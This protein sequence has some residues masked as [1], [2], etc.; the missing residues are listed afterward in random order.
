AHNLA[1]F[2][3]VILVC[4]LVIATSFWLVY[5]RIRLN[6]NA[7]MIAL[8]VAFLAMTSS[9]LHWLS[10]PHIFTFLFL[11][12][13]IAVLDRM[14][15]GEV[16]RWWLL[17]LLM[18]LW[19]NFH[20]A[21]IAG[22]MTWFLFGFGILMDQVW[23]KK[24]LGEGLPPKF[25][26]FY[27]LGGGASLL[28]SFINPAGIGIWGTSV[29]YLGESFLVDMTQEYQSPDFHLYRMWPFL[30]FI[31]LLIILFAINKR[32]RK[33]RDLVPA[34]AWM[35][36]GLYS[37]RNIPLF[38]IISAPLLATELDSLFIT[39]A[40]KFKWVDKLKKVD[41][42]YV[43][44]DGQL[45]GVVWPGLVVLLAVVGLSL[46]FT[47]DFQQSG[48]AY[49]PEVF[50]VDAVAWLDENPQEGNMFN[51]FIW[52]G[53]LLYEEWP[54]EL[55]FIDGQTDFYG[56]AL[57]RQ[58]LEVL[59]AVDGWEEILAEYDVA[60]AILPPEEVVTH[61]MVVDLGWEE[62]YRDDVAVIVHR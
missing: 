31:V 59:M 52:G 5:R 4:A 33:F 10:R 56:E 36:M 1:G 21:F 24:P 22:F 11:A 49:D 19:A 2:A 18:V 20:G 15:R 8:L 30:L 62:V 54:D 27:L 14:A 51:Y 23:G 16:K 9:A 7:L 57:T 42:R 12:L 46:G 61:L 37:S 38:A 58:Y 6:T 32:D 41:D 34:V 53:Y 44:L 26:Q 50:P 17:P 55:V 47:F 43:V 25:W 28:A 35:A 45:K 39:A 29:G 3:G 48:Y 13:W 40:D 60:W